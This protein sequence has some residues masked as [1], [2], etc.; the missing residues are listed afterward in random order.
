MLYDYL[1]VT[2]YLWY[3]FGSI[4]QAL[5]FTS[6]QFAKALNTSFYYKEKLYSCRSCREEAF[7]VLPDG[8]FMYSFIQ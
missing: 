8:K 4:F 1:P 3:F 2:L 7:A 6:K 5:K